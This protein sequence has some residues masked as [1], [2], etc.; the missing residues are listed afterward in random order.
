LNDTSQEL[1]SRINRHSPIGKGFLFSDDVLLKE[2]GQWAQKKNIPLIL[3]TDSQHYAQEIKRVRKGVE[4][5]KRG[6]ANTEKNIREKILH[7][8]REIRDYYMQLSKEER[9]PSTPHKVSSYQ[10]MIQEL[11]YGKEPIYSEANVPHW[12][13]KMRQKVTEIQTTGTLQLYEEICKDKRYQ[14]RKNFMKIWG[15]GAEK[16]K[17]WVNQ[18]IYTLEDIKEKSIRLTSQQKIGI[19]YYEDLQHSIP[20]EVVELYKNELKKKIKSMKAYTVHDAGSHAMGKRDSMDMDFILSY[21]MQKSEK[22]FPHPLAMWKDIIYDTLL[23]GKKKKIYIVK[24]EK[25]KYYRQMDVSFVPESQLF[26]YKLYFCHGREFSKKIRQIASQKGFL[27]NEKGLF[28]KN[29]MEKVKESFHTE[30]ELFIFLGFT[31]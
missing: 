28:Y 5:K 30:K 20:Y 17:E 3:E 18:G 26:W 2:I 15:V 6:G 23:D 13:P 10:K 22:D 12:T 29:S 16:A 14:S 1:N 24:L 27:L 31:Q 21:S 25:D 19:R 4:E 9:E 7:L 8:F 11:E